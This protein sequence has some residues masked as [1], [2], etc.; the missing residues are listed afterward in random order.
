VEI[1]AGNPELDF[2]IESLNT[3]TLGD[4]LGA[5][6]EMSHGFGLMF[7]ETHVRTAFGEHA[8]PDSSYLNTASGI[9]SRVGGPAHGSVVSAPGGGQHISTT[10]SFTNGGQQSPQPQE[11]GR[12]Y[13]VDR[14]AHA[15]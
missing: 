15:L 4:G 12:S 5:P 6:D 7:G 10:N 2:G 3:Y 1:G 14:I 13:R 11:A 8:V 9:Q